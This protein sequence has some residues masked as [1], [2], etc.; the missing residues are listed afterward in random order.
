MIDQ[1]TWNKS[2]YTE[3]N[4]GKHTHIKTIFNESIQKHY[5]NAKLGSLGADT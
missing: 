3:D 1:D 5:L 2:S 4:N